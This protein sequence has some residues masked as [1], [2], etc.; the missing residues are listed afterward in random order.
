MIKILII[1][2]YVA[3]YFGEYAVRT[4]IK[5]TTI[6][7]VFDFKNNEKTLLGKFLSGIA[8]K[9]ETNRFESGFRLITSTIQSQNNLKFITKNGSTYVTSDEPEN[10]DITFPEFV[11]MRHRLYSP[12]EILELRQMLKL[13]DHRKTH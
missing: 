3:V 5:E 9:D 7:L 13:N 6:L 10:F 1:K 12:A 8:D 4:F 2:T 11:V